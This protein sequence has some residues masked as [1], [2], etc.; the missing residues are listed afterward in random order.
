MSLSKYF[1]TALL[2]LVSTTNASPHHVNARDAFL[3]AHV[4]V[5]S[6]GSRSDVSPFPAGQLC[7]TYNASTFQTASGS[8]FEITCGFDY[9]G[10]DLSMVYVANLTACTFACA[11]NKECVAAS[12]SGSACY[13]KSELKPARH[14]AG[15][16][17][18][19]LVSTASSS[20][21]TSFSNGTA[22]SSSGSSLTS[23][24]SSSQSTSASSS[25]TMSTSSSQ[26]ARTIS[27][28]SNSTLVS[29]S[30]SSSLGTTTTSSVTGSISSGPS[31]SSISP[32]Q[33]TATIASSVGSFFA[34]TGAVLTCPSNNGT[35]YESSSGD[36]FI[37]ECYV[38]RYGN[39]MGSV[40]IPSLKLAD[41]IEACASTKGCV[42]VSMSGSACYMKYKAGM[43]YNVASRIQG[44]RLVA[45]ATKSFSAITT[46]SSASS[47]YVAGPQTQAP[48]CPGSNA[49][50]YLA[51]NGAVFA[52]ECFIDRYGNDL[53]MIYV[54]SFQACIDACAST[55]G[56]ADVSLSGSACYMKS[57]VGAAYRQAYNIQGAT[58]VSSATTTSSFSGTFTSSGSASNLAS[59]SSSSTTGNPT[60]TSPSA[61]RTS[62]FSY[63]SSSSSSPTPSPSSSSST[64]SVV[65]STSSSASA[66]MPTLGFGQQCTSASQ[67]QT[68]YCLLSKCSYQSQDG[69]PC[70]QATDCSSGICN[71]YGQCT[72]GAIGVGCFYDSDCL[73]SLCVSNQC[74]SVSSSKQIPATSSTTSSTSSSS[75][76]T[77]TGSPNGASCSYPTDCLS[78][79][80]LL[81]TCQDKSQLGGFCS[82]ASDC[83]AGQCNFEQEV[84]VT[85]ADG[86]SCSQ[87]SDCSSA[88]CNTEGVCGK[89]SD[90][91]AC[92]N[93]NDCTS[94]FCNGERTCGRLQDGATCST[95]SDCYSEFCNSMGSC[96]VLSDGAPCKQNTDCF[97]ECNVASY[98]GPLTTCFPLCPQ[99]AGWSCQT[100]ASDTPQCVF[101]C[102]SDDLD[103]YG[104]CR[105]ISDGT[106]VGVQYANPASPWPETGE[107][108]W[109]AVTCCAPDGSSCYNKFPNFAGGF[110]GGQ[111]PKQRQP[112]ATWGACSDANVDATCEW[113]SSFS[114]GG[115]QWSLNSGFLDRSH[116][117]PGSGMGTVQVDQSGTM[118]LEYPGTTFHCQTADLSVL[119]YD[120]G[121]PCIA[122]LECQP[123]PSGGSVYIEFDFPCSCDVGGQSCPSG[124]ATIQV[125]Y[126]NSG[127]NSGP[128]LCSDKIGNIGAG[129]NQ[130]SFSHSVTSS[131]C[132]AHFS[133]TNGNIYIQDVT[134]A[135]GNA[136][137]SA[138]PST[139]EQ[140][141]GCQGVQYMAMYIQS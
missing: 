43:P 118:F 134:F 79:A 8:V 106:Y 124:T 96:G 130:Y 4:P 6:L 61:S 28:V 88:F 24:T 57:K 97:S 83:A 71:S 52:V 19:R 70:E 78:G 31:E 80:C 48:F 110:Y 129:S 58:F 115:F 40:T 101:S 39:D 55:S 90:G 66:S 27:S 111:D 51:Q 56:C 49:T 84:C 14:N 137:I 86:T 77:P 30:P 21:F 107:E 123:P 132:G 87:A 85:G 41:C 37:V 103:Q 133:I 34:S 47:G 81:Y 63:S 18:V 140:D 141:T 114:G 20:S 76:P 53:K 135:S 1:L 44:A 82:I 116:I 72:S 112:S 108:I 136:G 29:E 33:S 62:I 109:Y 7:P 65:S 113:D 67:C 93:N 122:D 104:N 46:S 131:K 74:G 68:G 10:G 69:G 138:T 98:C 3:K 26:T 36:V 59:L 119:Y 16:D 54:S 5:I 94:A 95:G 2:I 117:T 11:A 22:T 100:S 89:S 32:I 12:L 60:L 13:L 38:D 50:Q 64:S 91:A 17:A 125:Y 9:A 25:Q 92:T 75:A 120:N 128:L 45:T 35:M 99:T 105:T 127:S 126:P 139:S 102:P 73:S 23:F 121:N 42:D 15:V